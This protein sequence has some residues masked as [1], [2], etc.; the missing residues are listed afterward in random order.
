MTMAYVLLFAG[1]S[2]QHAGMLRWVDAEPAAAGTLVLLAS[3]LGAD[4]RDRL[5]D[6]AWATRNDVAQLLVTGLGLAAWQ[7]LAPR[8]PEP[9]AVAG[10]SVGELAAFAAAG[11]FDAA[12]AMALARDRAAAM[13]RA[14]A[15]QAAGMSGVRG[16]SDDAVAAA[17]SRHG[18]KM[19][20]HI[21]PDSVVIGG[22]LAALAA[23]EEELARAGARVT[24]L[25]VQVASH[26]HWMA[27]AATA[28]ARRLDAVDFRPPATSLVCNRTGTR[29]RDTAALKTALAEQIANPLLWNACLETLAER[30]PAGALE[31]GG[32]DALARHWRERDPAVPAR[33]ADDFR[34]AD[35][36]VRWVSGL[37]R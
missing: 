13:Q 26:T 2:S 31:I 9:L 27:A 29:L 37:S 33:S 20:I 7:V 14:A 25:A 36:V 3:A 19:A 35:A 8:L 32:G 18:T 11:V 30:Q 5:Q 10:Y 17:C 24:R 23:A 34:S 16:A 15:G 6:P 28:F 12:Q 21:A 4:W 22:P 1:Q